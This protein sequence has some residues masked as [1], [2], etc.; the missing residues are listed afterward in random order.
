MPPSSPSPPLQAP[1]NAPSRF[2]WVQQLG[3]DC[4]ISFITQGG[5]MGPAQDADCSERFPYMCTCECFVLVLT[6]G[7]GLRA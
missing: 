7:W 4:R 2:Y 3:Y 5:G 6:L 1:P